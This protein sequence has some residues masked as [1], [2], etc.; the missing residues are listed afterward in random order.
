MISG[1]KKECQSILSELVSKT[2]WSR[3]FEKECEALSEE[4]E[5]VVEVEHMNEPMPT[6]E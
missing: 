6:K 4:D 5:E 1:K 3:Q 2:Q